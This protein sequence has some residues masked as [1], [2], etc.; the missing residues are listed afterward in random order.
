MRSVLPAVAILGL[1]VLPVE[2]QQEYDPMIA[3]AA[4][5]IVAQ[6]IGDIRNGFPWNIRLVEI[7]EPSAAPS[8]PP[9]PDFTA[10]GSIVTV[11]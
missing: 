1:L 9:A 11:N 3:A 4:A 7:V 10:T 2:A 6:K 5:H 8:V